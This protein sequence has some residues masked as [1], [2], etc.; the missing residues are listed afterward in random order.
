MKV[1]E[2]NV[3]YHPGKDNVVA[4]A[5]SRMSMESKS[6]VEDE[7][8]ELVKDIHRLARR[9]VRLVYSTSGDA[10]VYPSSK[11]F[12]VVEVKKGQNLD[13]VLMELKDSVLI[14][15]NE[16]FALEGDGVHRYQDRLFVPNVDDLQTKIVAEAHC[17]RYSIYTDPSKMY[18]DLKKIY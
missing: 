7:K 10:S 1:Y 3:Y 5:L 2:I 17:S 6:H 18:H 8:K 14:K 13:H 9:V 15:M 11:S 4:D 16:S 12:L